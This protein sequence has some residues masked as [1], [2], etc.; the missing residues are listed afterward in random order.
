[1]CR[2]CCVLGVVFLALVS[3]A[4]SAEDLAVTAPEEVG[5]SK[6]RLDRIGRFMR[7]TVADKRAAGAVALVARH[8]KI[9]YC[10]AFGMQNTETDT[11]MAKD[12]IFRIYSMTKPIVTVGVMMLYEE[13][14]FRLGDPIGNYLPEL[15]DMKI[16]KEKID[17]ETGEKTLSLVPPKHPI[18]IRDLLRHTAGLPYN[19]PPDSPAGKMYR[20]ANLFGRNQTLAQL[21][22]ALGKRPLSTEPGTVMEYGYST[23]VLARLIEV[24]SGLHLDDYL[25]QRILRPLGMNDTGF[26]VPAKKAE[27]FAALYALRP[28]GVIHP[29]LARN[30]LNWDYLKRPTLLSGGGGLVSTAPDYAVFCQMLLNKGELDGLRLLSPKTVELMTQNHLTNGVSSGW[31]QHIGFGLGFFVEPEPGVMGEI[32]SKGT[33]GWSGGANTRF[34]ID[35]E[36]ELITVF[37]V[38]T[39]G[40]PYPPADTFKNLAY[41]AII[42]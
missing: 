17:S 12:T 5:L 15:R 42:R 39:F 30:R 19:L 37:L 31:L 13:G 7:K 41:Q 28:D 11:P 22:E 16:A 3:L 23:D 14:R 26:Y 25:E 21:I 24:L 35:P 38:Q 40:S 8:G 36:E 33:Y 4:V 34:W 27:R 9:A 29:V 2:R 6:E 10:E 18:T 1:M 32:G 20:D